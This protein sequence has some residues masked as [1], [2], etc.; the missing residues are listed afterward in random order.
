[1]ALNQHQIIDRF[2][3]TYREE[4]EGKSDEEI[5]SLADEWTQKEYGKT[6]KPYKDPTPNING[7][8]L[9]SLS[10]NISNPTTQLEKTDVSPKA[11]DGLFGSVANILTNIPLVNPNYNPAQHFTESGL[12]YNKETGS[13]ISPEFFQYTMNN[14]LAG[15]FYQTM[16][17]EDKYK[18]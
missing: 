1:M 13:G 2:R 18:V 7:V 6:L 5:Y 15:M 4:M 10:Q 14:S 17:G 3:R 8:S 11:I 12:F 16:Y 9:N